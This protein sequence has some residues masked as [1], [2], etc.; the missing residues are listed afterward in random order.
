GLAAVDG[1]EPSPKSHEK[2]RA[3]FSG[4]VV[5][6]AVEVTVSGVPPD[7]TSAPATALGG[8]S[9]VATKLIFRTAPA[10]SDR[11]YRLPPGPR[12]RSRGATKL[13]ERLFS[14]RP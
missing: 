11:K 8:R 1:G 12:S 7:V 3:S 5:P 2:L 9:T 13:V 4:S 14:C 10:P 6:A